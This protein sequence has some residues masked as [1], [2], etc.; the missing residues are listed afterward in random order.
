[1]K[2][3][4]GLYAVLTVLVFLALSGKTMYDRVSSPAETFREGSGEPRQELTLY[5]RS[6]VLMDADTDQKQMSGRTGTAV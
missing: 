6:A 2:K 3:K 1:M 4:K 5:A